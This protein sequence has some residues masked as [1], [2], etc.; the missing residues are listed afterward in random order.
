MALPQSLVWEVRT[1]GN[2]ANGGA[3]LPTSGG[4]DRSQQDS[5]H[6]TF[7]GKDVTA[8]TTGASATI[9]ISGY[10]VEAGDIGNIL[11]ITGGTKFI[12][13]RYYIQSVSTANN[14]WTLDRNCCSGAASAM[15]GRMGGCVADLA[16]IGGYLVGSETIHIK[17]GNY[18]VTSTTANVAGG[19]L[20]SSTAITGIFGYKDTRLDFAEAPILYADYN[21]ATGYYLI[22]VTATLVCN[23]KAINN[24][25]DSKWK[26]FGVPADTVS[27][28]VGCSCHNFFYGFYGATAAYCTMTRDSV[29]TGGYGFQSCTAYNCYASYALF[30][31]YSSNAHSCAA[32]SC[33]TGFRDC[34]VI[35]NC[36]A[37]SCRYGTDSA[38]AKVR[39]T[40][41]IAHTCT[42][43]FSNTTGNNLVAID[44]TC[45]IYNGSYLKFAYYNCPVV[46]YQ[47]ASTVTY[48]TP[49][50]L[51]A[52]PF[53]D[54]ANGDY[55][56][57]NV[58]GGGAVLKDQAF[59]G[60]FLPDLLKTNFAQDIG[61][62]T[63]PVAS[64]GG[65][66]VFF[67]PPRLIGG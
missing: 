37:K 41:C 28:I 60:L 46:I 50:A 19:R 51:T 20:D 53:K 21:D 8:T 58:A 10:T 56:L 1:T 32:I 64:G 42:N 49:I 30:G 59:T 9:T 13:G 36:L 17:A 34:P 2:N 16:L 47:Q 39:A 31:F 43:G 33:D 54:A 5:P 25:P 29:L 48:M 24:Y 38:G 3:F 44:C 23:L 66:T 45:A 6:V 4:T 27:V 22:R 26:F 15:T 11:N 35:T 55:R 57:N 12:T 61:A 65:G 7:D 52:D 40:A 62:A 67:L 14:T 63:E 18:Y